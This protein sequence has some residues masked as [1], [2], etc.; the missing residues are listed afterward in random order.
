M[1]TEVWYPLAGLAMLSIL[2]VVTTAALKFPFKKAQPW[3]NWG[4]NFIACGLALAAGV[5]VTRDT[6]IE[7]LFEAIAGIHPAALLVMGLAFVALVWYV[8]LAAVPDEWS[9]IAMSGGL[10]VAAF[11]APVMGETAVP[12]GDVGDNIQAIVDDAGTAAVGFTDGWFEGA[13]QARE[14]R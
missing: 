8:V 3:I 13:T 7:D 11:F 10:I 4:G 1:R 5:Y 14:S 6:W 9:S 2:A 12:P